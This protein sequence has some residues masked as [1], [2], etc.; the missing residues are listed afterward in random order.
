MSVRACASFKTKLSIECRPKVNGTHFVFGV[1]LYNIYFYS[2]QECRYGDQSRWC[3]N[4]APRQCYD[5]ENRCCETCKRHDIAIDGCKYGDRSSSCIVD[6]CFYGSLERKKVTCCLTCSLATEP[7][8]T[9]TSYPTA[10]LFSVFSTTFPPKHNEDAYKVTSV[11]PYHAT[12]Y[13][14]RKTKRRR[15]T[16]TTTTS[17]TTS[18]ATITSTTTPSTIATVPT[19]PSTNSLVFFTDYFSILFPKK[20]TNGTNYA[21]SGNTILIRYFH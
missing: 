1:H 12:T 15:S 20:Y 19:T 14:R 18:E 21:L 8:V 9:S 6:D 13:R 11:V 3:A 7:P 2:Y 17:T 16:T 5:I 10:D 4:I